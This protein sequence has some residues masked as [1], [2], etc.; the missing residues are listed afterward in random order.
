MATTYDIIMSY[1]KAAIPE[2]TNNSAAAID[3]KIASALAPTVDNTILELS[4]TKT[5]IA[6]IIG[7]QRYG[8]SQY[9]IDTA[10]NYQDEYDL[11]EVDENFNPIYPKIDEVARIVK[12]AA[13]KALPSGNLQVLTL[14]VAALDDATGLLRALTPSEKSSFDGYMTQFEIPGLPLIKSSTDAVELS[15][16]ATITYFS[17]YNLTNIKTSIDE[18]LTNFRDEFSFDG[19][20]YI[21]DLETYLKTNIAGIRNVSISNT[22]IDSVAF[23]SQ[24]E[25]SSGYF[26]YAPSITSAGFTY[27]AI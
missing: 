10:L 20:L 24:T 5:E 21:N 12:H 15:F 8:R 4:N 17:T 18:Q 3:K 1:L 11:T 2:L 13:F 23:L 27:I 25:L 9:Y 6:N 7:Q 22:L 14:K 26:N 16:M 19:T